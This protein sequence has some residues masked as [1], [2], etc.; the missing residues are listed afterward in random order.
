M[1]PQVS[2][3]QFLGMNSRNQFDLN[4]VMMDDYKERPL[5]NI[6]AEYESL[7]L[8]SGHENLKEVQLKNRTSMQVNT[9]LF[10]LLCKNLKAT[11]VANDV[12]KEDDE[13]C[14]TTSKQRISLEI[15]EE[16]IPSNGD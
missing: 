2:T 14:K 16:E 11:E 6:E 3:K 4:R 8:G 1:P 13:S 5:S 10:N 12:I 9:T 7:F 15:S